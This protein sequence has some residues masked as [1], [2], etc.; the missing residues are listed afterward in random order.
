MAMNLGSDGEREPEVM[1]D[2]NTTPLIDV[3]LVLIIMLIITIPVQLHAVNLNL[4]QVKAPPPQQPPVVV[5]V[6]INADGSVLWNDA[7][8]SDQATLE[9]KLRQAA[10]QANP[11]EVQLRPDGSAA[12]GAVARVLAA[13]QRSG[14]TKLGMVGNERFG[15]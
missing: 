2:I 10:T 14:V 7:V 13:A 8:V 4:P 3:M 11:P 6:K 9:A 12:Y 1:M 5:T 15:S